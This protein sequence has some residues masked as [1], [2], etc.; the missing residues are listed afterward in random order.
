MICGSTKPHNTRPRSRARVSR[1]FTLLELVLVVAVGMILAA[2]AIPVI[3]NTMRVYRMR[4]AVTSLTGA[5]TS[6]RYQ[7]I[8]H[9]CK[10]QVVFTASTYSY[11]VQSEAPAYGGLACAAAFSNVGG[12]VPLMGEGVALSPATITLTFS[13]GGS[14]TSTPAA[15]PITLTLTYTGFTTTVPTETITVSNYG[16]VT[17]TP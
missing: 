15:S 8:F 11:Q 4:S 17:V 7:A 14:V 16:N 1:G 6:S 3:T 5:I 9:G 13:P 2:M 12:A 10:S